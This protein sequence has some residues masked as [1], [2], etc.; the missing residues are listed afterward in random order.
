MV[1]L[2]ETG[3]SPKRG[4]A[5]P[6][7]PGGGSPGPFIMLLLLSLLAVGVVAGHK[8]L[9]GKEK[10]PIVIDEDGNARL[11]PERQAKLDKELEELDNAVQ[12]ALIATVDGYYPCYTCPDGSP[13]IYLYEGEIWRYGSTRKGEQ[14]RYPDGNYGTANVFYVEQFWGTELEC[15]KMEKIKIYNYPLLPE[16]LKRDIQLYRPP[17][18]KIDN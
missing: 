12:Y 7:N 10:S 3:Y 11:S 14:G 1:H 18:N 16:A 8:I 2:P 6:S 9:A 5:A 17:G 13:T 15:R 4:S